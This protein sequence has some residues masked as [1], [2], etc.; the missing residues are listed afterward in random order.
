MLCR[1]SLEEKTPFSSYCSDIINFVDSIL[2]LHR[3]EFSLTKERSSVMDESSLGLQCQ[4]IPERQ[5]L[6][7]LEKTN[8]EIEKNNPF[9][10]ESSIHPN[11]TSKAEG[12]TINHILDELDEVNGVLRTENEEEEEEKEININEAVEF[13]KRNVLDELKQDG[14]LDGVDDEE[15]NMEEEEE[16]QANNKKRELDLSNKHTDFN[17]NV[18]KVNSYQKE[19]YY[20][21]SDNEHKVGRTKNSQKI[22]ISSKSQH[23]NIRSKLNIG[24]IKVNRQNSVEADTKGSFLRKLETAF[25]RPKLSVKKI[26]NL[27]SI[28]T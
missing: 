13:K 11:N 18:K 14:T 27:V 19:N 15:K 5:P 20:Y 9:S 8:S 3:Q 26:I 21:D 24:N 1:K 4:T 6:S 23:D 17:R 16:E 2:D 12:N 10:K 7:E 28:K 25:T 22:N